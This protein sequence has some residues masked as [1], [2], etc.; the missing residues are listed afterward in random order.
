MKI[1]FHTALQRLRTCEDVLILTHANPDGD[2]L[3][4]EG[5]VACM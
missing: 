5:R 1:E 3:G 2:T 4:A